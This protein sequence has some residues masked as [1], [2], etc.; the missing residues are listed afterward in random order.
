MNSF[1]SSLAVLAF[2]AIL[3]L[4]FLKELRGGKSR[5]EQH[6]DAYDSMGTV[7][8][9]QSDLDS[10]VQVYIDQLDR[11][12]KV[13]GKPIPVSGVSEQG[14]TI[15]RPGGCSDICLHPSRD[16][17]TVSDPHL[18][19]CADENGFSVSE[20][21]QTTNGTFNSR[22]SRVTGVRLNEKTTLLRAGKQWL[23]FRVVEAMAGVSGDTIVARNMHFERDDYS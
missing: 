2:C 22:G 14:F 3:V 20:P 8:C 18:V 12:A 16:V 19:I 15:G 9:E 10:R 7:R 17:K 13:I 21:W 6:R 5:A 11:N 1:I 4:M 23:R